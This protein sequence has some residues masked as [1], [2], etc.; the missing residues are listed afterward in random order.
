MPLLV[1]VFPLRFAVPMMLLFDLGA[2]ALLGLRNRRRLNLPEL[3]RLLPILCLGM[4][5]GVTLLA[6]A[7]ERWLLPVLG[8]FLIGFALWSLTRRGEPTLIS[9]RWALPAGLAGGAFTAL[10]GTGGPLYTVYL[11][12]RLVDKVELRA[13]LGVLVFST[14]LIRL[15]LF[16]AGGFYAQPGLLMLSLV[17]MPCAL[18]GFAIGSALHARIATARALQLIWLLLIGSGTSLVLRALG[19][20]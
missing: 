13:T 1:Q 16:T 17:L 6:R 4:L 2:G 20:G 5:A 19:P 7:P 14:A 3:K 11:A 15:L 18:A 12:R 9:S 10:Y 8:A